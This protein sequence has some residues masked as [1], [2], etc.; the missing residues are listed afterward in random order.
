[1]FVLDADMAL[2]RALKVAT[3]VAEGLPKDN[4]QSLSACVVGPILDAM[5]AVDASEGEQ[6]T[7]E[8]QA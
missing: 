1:M 2:A 8:T 5:A 7:R 3:G 6:G 4:M